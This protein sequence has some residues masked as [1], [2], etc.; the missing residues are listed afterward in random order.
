VA[1]VVAH[2]SGVQRVLA[3][4][5]DQNLPVTRP[6]IASTCGLSRPT[7]FTAM[8]RLEEIGL[9]TEVGQ[10]SGEPGR[11]ATLYEVA[12][13]AGIVL[14]LDI[15]GSNLRA[16]VADIRGQILA[17]K[18]EPT[19][20]RGGV[21]I[22]NQAIKLAQSVLTSVGSTNGAL[23]AIGVSVPGAVSADGN[24][25]HYA[26]NIDQYGPF[27]FHTPLVAALNAPVILDN[28]VNLAAEGERWKGVAQSLTN[29][30]VIA[31]G[32]GIGAGIVH[33][34]RLLRGAHGAAGEVAFLPPN[35]NHRRVD[36]PNHDEAGGLSLLNEAQALPGWKSTPPATVEELFSRAALGEEPAT[37]LVEQECW[38]IASVIASICAVVDP[39]TVILTGGVGVN[40]HLISRAES[41]AAEMTPF[42]PSV[43]R[44]GLG[45]DAS[46][47]GAI[48]LAIQFAQTQLIQAVVE[49]DK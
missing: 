40:D 15:G 30:A 29:F 47:I 21:S 14:G 4:L 28:N 31:V 22:V 35:N 44:S 38:R 27:D 45:G 39:E 2:R 33:E 3:F 34:G 8:A 26:S 43:I 42:P 32:A 36:A 18:R 16:A 9:V 5:L 10:R 48:H 12:P 49:S 46:L 1:N 7:I 23:A 24:T 19:A 13:S 41:L 20:H 25:V 17:E 6:L 11:S 37:T